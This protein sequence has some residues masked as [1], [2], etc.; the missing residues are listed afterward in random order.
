MYPLRGSPFDFL[1]R[2]FAKPMAEKEE[3]LAVVTDTAIETTETLNKPDTQTSKLAQSNPS[4]PIP[5]DKVQLR[6]LLISGQTRDVLVS[7]N[8]TVSQIV[9][10]LHSSWPKGGFYLVLLFKGPLLASKNT[11]IIQ[12]RLASSTT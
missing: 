2:D 9:H 8:D 4:L 1:R 12:K 3:P 5:S 11:Q 10:D 6:L 7:P